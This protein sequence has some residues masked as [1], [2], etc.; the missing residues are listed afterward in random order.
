MTVAPADDPVRVRLDATEADVQVPVAVVDQ[1]PSAQTL[2]RGTRVVVAP[3]AM[4]RGGVLRRLLRQ[5]S[6]PVSRAVRC[7]A[8]LVR[9]YVDI[10][11]D[12]GAAWGITP[13]A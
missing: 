10:G 13:P 4:R 3:T 8:L 2:P 6:V 7:T 5:G 9:G 11:A 1:I 12:D